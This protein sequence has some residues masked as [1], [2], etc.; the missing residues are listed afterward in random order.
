MLNLEGILGR[1]KKV[2]TESVESE[3]LE[4]RLLRDGWRSRSC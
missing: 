1:L 3:I 4:T 2:E